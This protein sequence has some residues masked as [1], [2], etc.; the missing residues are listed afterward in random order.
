LV[1]GRYRNRSRPVRPVTAVN[2]PVTNGKSNPGVLSLVQDG[3]R[4]VREKISNL[5]VF[6]RREQD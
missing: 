4:V 1:T 6:N 2:Q 3:W 5:M